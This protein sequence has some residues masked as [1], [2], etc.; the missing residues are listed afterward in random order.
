MEFSNVLKQLREEK[1]L[2]QKD[3]AQ[4]LGI[5]RQ[6]VA[7]YEVGKR[8]PDYHILRKL[9]DYF[10]VSIDYLLGR[11][12]CKDINALTIGKNIDL[13]RGGRF[14]NEFSKDISGKTGTLIFPELLEV[15]CNGERVPN[16]GT[17]KILAR[18]AGVRDSFFYT[19]N[20]LETLRKEKELC[21]NEAQ[22]ADVCHAGK[23]SGEASENS[24]LELRQWA[25]NEENIEFIRVAKQI[26][27]EKVKLSLLF[28]IIESIKKSKQ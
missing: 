10:S 17:I 18:Y 8:E 22:L 28:S 3:I 23:N 20:T 6:A 5:T 16:T 12:F 24:N 27:D 4:Y 13:I 15:Y 9:A 7:F 14:F 26:K 2:S 19:H 11:V 25:L 21:R 1:S